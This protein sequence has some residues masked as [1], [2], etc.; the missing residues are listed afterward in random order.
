MIEQMVAQNPK[1]ALAYIHRWRYA[2]EFFGSAQAS[3]IRK[4]WSWHPTIPRF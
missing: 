1:V 2:Q 3:D 4:P